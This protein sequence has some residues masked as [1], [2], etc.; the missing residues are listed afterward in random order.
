KVWDEVA[1]AYQAFRPYSKEYSL[2]T[3]FSSELFDIARNV[4][5]L[6]EEMQKP[7]EKRLREYRD[8]ALPSLQQSMYSTAPV[9]DSLEIAE[10]AL[11][12]RFM[13]QELGPDN[14]LVKKV[15]ER[16]SPEQ[17]AEDYVKTSKL[18]DVAERKRLA[19]D[20]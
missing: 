2:T 8:S 3:P 13:R 19:T 17:A 11:N 6:P 16:K 7:S 15:L 1:A 20:L 10:L 18:K 14:E 5:R 12:F 9:T 4:L